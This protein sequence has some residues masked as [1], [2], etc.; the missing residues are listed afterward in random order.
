M[1]FLSG[2]ALDECDLVDF[3]QCGDSGP[4]LF[5]RRLAEKRHA[6]VARHPPDLRRRALIEN[7]FADLL[8]QVEQLMDRASSAET[9]AA[10][11]ETSGALIERDVTPFL[12]L[13]AALRQV[14]FGI[15]YFVLTMGTNHTDQPLRENA[16]QRRNEIVRFD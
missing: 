10:A 3:L 7:Q 15:S 2:L 9:G 11:L 13:E 12:G 8:A 16:V 4:R 14:L 5:E 6:F 1:T